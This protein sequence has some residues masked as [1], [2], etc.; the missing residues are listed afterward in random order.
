[1]NKES[2]QNQDRPNNTS[3]NQ[4]K[5][6]LETL[7]TAYLASNPIQRN[8]RKVNEVEIR[9]NSNTRKYKPTS[10]IDYDNVVKHLYSYGFKTTLPEGFH[11]LRIFHEYMDSRGNMSMSNIRTEIVGLDL[12]Q[13]YCR[14]NS[15]Q[16]LLDMP[17]TTYDKIKFTQKSLPEYKGER[18]RPV[19]FD[20]FNLKVSYQLEQ[21]STARSDFIRGILDKWTE[22]L[23]SFRYLNRVRFTHPDLPI[24]A[25]ISIVRS[26][27]SNRG[28][29]VK[30]YDVQESGVLQGVE[31]Y[32]IEMEIDNTRVGT[33]TKWNTVTK[34]VDL[35]RKTIRI[36]LSGLQGTAYPIS[37]AEKDEVIFE[38]MKIIRGDDYQQGRVQNRDF[39]G[40]SSVTLQIENIVEHA[41]HSL[42]PNIRKHY[43]VTD[44]ADGE[45]R[46]IFVNSRG[47]IYMI[48]TNMNVIFTGAKTTNK[49]VFDSIIDGEFIKYDKMGNL[50]QLYAAFDIYFVH[51]KS[52]RE[53]GFAKT[54]EEPPLDFED[55]DT[56]EDA[57]IDD[58]RTSKLSVSEI[59]DKKQKKGEEGETHKGL[60]TAVRYRLSLLQQFV[61]RL[62]PVSI[63]VGNKEGDQENKACDFK[64]KCKTFCM[65]SPGVTIF[66]ACAKIL[67]D[68]D[69][70]IYPYNTD[71]LIFTPSDTGVGVDKVGSAAKLQKISWERSFKWKPPEFNTIDFLVSIKK[72]K[73]G[74][75]EIH[76]IFQDGK[77]ME[78]LQNFV[79]YKT[80][81]LRCGFNEKTDGFLQ[82]F[83][84]LVNGK[85][86]VFGDNENVSLYKPV[87]FVPTD[88]YDPNACY[89]NIL[90]REDKN[91]H[92]AL[93]SEEGEYFEDHMIV[94]FS[95][96]PTNAPGWRWKPLRVR[97]DKTTELRNGLN[98]FG[99]AYHV[100]NTNWQSIHRPV[101]KKMITDGLDIPEMVDISDEG[102]AGEGVYYNRLG[103]LGEGT[104]SEKRTAGLR[105]FHNLY[106]KRNLILAVSQRKDT[107]I[108]YAVGKAGDLS[109]WIK[110]ELS[111]VFGIDISVPN[112]HN[113]LDGACARYLKLCRKVKPIPA[114]LFVNGTTAQLIRN[115]DAFST[116][117]DKAI[118]D[119]VFG[120][121][122]KDAKLLGDGVYKQYGVAQDGFNVSSCQFALH[123]FWENKATL[124]RFLRNLAEC[125]RLNGHFIGTCYDGDTVFKLLKNK[126]EGESMVI[127][128]GD[129]KIFELTK[130]YSHTGFVPD[131]TSIGYPINVYQ[132]TINKT[133]REYLV[134]FDYLVNVMSDYGFVLVEDVAAKQM[135][136]PA[137][138]GLFHE[139]FEHMMSEI[140]RK[141]HISSE[142]GTAVNMSTD[143]K[144]ISFLNRY[145]VF[146]KTTRVN[147]EKVFKL[148]MKRDIELP[149]LS[150]MEHKILEQSE[151]QGSQKIKIKAPKG[152]RVTILASTNEVVDVPLEKENVVVSTVKESPGP[153]M[154]L[155]PPPGPSEPPKKFSIK[156]K[157]PVKPS[158]E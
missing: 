79:Q 115:G 93:Y 131:D 31:T 47:W 157:K 78:G 117:K 42:V 103:A 123:Y 94:E 143:E 41:Q 25:D 68:I 86:P 59:R 56:V 101:T 106:V 64:I 154:V 144:R 97:Y 153:P 126:N 158:Q 127:F 58:K 7:L 62:N 83:Q 77:N 98:N 151:R 145:F 155:P 50:I 85:L 54:G 21:N 63:L 102:A 122:P 39:I 104:G 8:D 6:Q 10:R 66:Q 69:D 13:E 112:I 90:L 34:L 3:K 128:D 9:F 18:I 125:T 137:G 5:D 149:I 73:H 46:L 118:A 17:S 107:L 45:R 33:G 22:K 40:P 27:R 109:K 36:V 99:N 91:Q 111:F 51:R 82:P 92:L 95:Y 120:N 146:R 57:F 24:F 12:V 88:P 53:Y 28:E 70:G 75:D 89:A 119:A 130:K 32:E 110:A 114:A 38:Y 67:S 23:K 147:A 48:D 121:G 37:Y 80:L 76:H 55:G 52:T 44:K 124:H 138:T 132:E 140:K 105:D 139:M 156:I 43:T 113:R 14:T 15:I 26:S 148:H 134:N 4:S 136:L 72:D 142:Y 135:G 65:T 71:G 87:K 19:T 133:F 108:D 129:R 150:E 29:F 49:G 116:P 84:D 11:S 96:H 100:A 2:E 20:D 141:P 60:E 35:V 30:T 61:A 81:E 1:M 74:K 152:K 16:K